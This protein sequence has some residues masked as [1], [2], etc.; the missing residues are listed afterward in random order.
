LG[1][2]NLTL[3]F[4]FTIDI[5]PTSTTTQACCIILDEENDGQAIDILNDTEYLEE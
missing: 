4:H 3:F 2:Y 5:S 1:A